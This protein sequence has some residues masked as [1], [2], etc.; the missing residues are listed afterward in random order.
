MGPAR[1]RCPDQQPG[2]RR[3]PSWSRPA[4]PP[5]PVL[6]LDVS[7]V[8]AS[9]PLRRART[10]LHLAGLGVPGLPDLRMH[11]RTLALAHR[12]DRKPGSARP[13]GSVPPLPNSCRS[14]PLC[15]RRCQV[16]RR[17]FFAGGSDGGIAGVSAAAATGASLPSDA[18]LLK[19]DRFGSR[20]QRRGCVQGAVRPVPIVKNFV[21]AQDLS[22]MGLVPD[23]GAVQELAAA[24]P[25]PTFGNGIGPHRRQHTVRMISTDVCG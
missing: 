15:C 12:N 9:N 25:D 5:T 19:I 16:G 13:V 18:V 8:L 21:L 14:N 1:V 3:P 7:I 2:G 20:F 11:I 6:P 4:D 24:S 22:Q 17:V 23:E 10:R